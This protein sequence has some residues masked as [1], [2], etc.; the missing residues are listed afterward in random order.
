MGNAEAIQLAIAAL[1]AAISW[2][3]DERRLLEVVTRARDEGRP[4]S[5][6]ELDELERAMD[7]AR[8]RI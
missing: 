8:A 1:R 3:V 5:A 6:D 4:V 2:G 7:A